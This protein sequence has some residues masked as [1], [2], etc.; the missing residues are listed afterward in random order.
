VVNRVPVVTKQEAGGSGLG[1]VKYLLL[2]YAAIC[3]LEG[4]EPGPVTKGCER[5]M[6]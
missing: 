4:G 3:Q 1:K 6:G 2:L 5:G